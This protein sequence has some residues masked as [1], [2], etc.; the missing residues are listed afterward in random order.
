[1]IIE[2]DADQ[3]ENK[4]QYEKL[5][6]EVEKDYMSPGTGAGKITSDME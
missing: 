2:K 5:G 6:E 1:V 4:T 3:R